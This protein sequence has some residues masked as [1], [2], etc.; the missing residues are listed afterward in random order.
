MRNCQFWGL[1]QHPL[2]RYGQQK[3]RLIRTLISSLAIAVCDVKSCAPLCVD[4]WSSAC[5]SV[6]N[7]WWLWG[8]WSAK[9]GFGKLLVRI[10]Y[11]TVLFSVPTTDIGKGLVSD[12]V[13]AVWVKH[14]CVFFLEKNL[15]EARKWDFENEAVDNF[16]PVWQNL[17]Y[18]SIW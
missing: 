17:N 14:H 11:F 13:S 2:Q 9:C 4:N 18:F 7:E 15:L 12:C 16:V 10:E 8:Y 6:F 1:E 3:L 5:C